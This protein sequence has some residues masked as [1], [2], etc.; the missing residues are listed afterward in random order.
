M[1]ILTD[2]CLPASG[3]T[4]AEC[5]RLVPSCCCSGAGMRSLLCSKQGGCSEDRQ[6]VGAGK[7]F[8][9]QQS[10]PGFVLLL[11]LCLAQASLREK[12]RMRKSQRACKS[13]Q[14][15]DSPRKAGWWFLNPPPE[16]QEMLSRAIPVNPNMAIWGLAI[17]TVYGAV[18]LLLIFIF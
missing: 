13:Q 15:G 18:I 9:Q 16:K 17:P 2:S 6:V 1:L 11:G 10:P 8:L 7:A 4:A 5:A 14:I 3:K 12:R